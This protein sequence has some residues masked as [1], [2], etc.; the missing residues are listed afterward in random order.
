MLKDKTLFVVGAGASAD[1]G[2]PVGKEL[3]QK[4]LNLLK[5]F[6]GD[7]LSAEGRAENALHHF[8]GQTNR[9]ISQLL[10]KAREVAGALAQ[11]SSID[12]YI[13]NHQHDEDIALLGKLG[14]AACLLD[15][16]ARCPLYLQPTQTSGAL[17]YDIL[18]HSW[19]GQLFQIL[20][21]GH[22]KQTM[23]AMFEDASFVVF[24]YDRCIQQ[25]FRHAV[26]NYFRIP[27]SE[28]DQIVA[29]CSIYHPYGSL[30]SDLNGRI[31]P[32]GGRDRMGTIPAQLLVKVAQGLR[33]YSEYVEDSAQVQATANALSEVS[34]VVYLG[35]AFHR[36][37]V[38]LLK[39]IA[40]T[41]SSRAIATVFGIPQAAHPVVLQDVAKIQGR[42][43]RQLR[44][45]LVPEK[46]A[47]FMDSHR[48][49]LSSR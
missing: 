32:F 43:V 46:C 18:S 27:L 45:N 10:G 39:K 5:T 34:T 14:I 35:F 47:D 25:Y 42:D 36:Q 33:T 13:E 28:A 22:N 49:L 9:S 11:A 38:R 7:P 44:P 37:N 19:L 4:I 24:N 48:L 17:H 26:S 23:P 8:A 3:Q 2:L 21:E 15:S 30:G 20:V 41:N 6:P 16:E 1:Y 29:R 31:T 40:P 12:S